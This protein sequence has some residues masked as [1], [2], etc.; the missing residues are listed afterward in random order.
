VEATA[1]SVDIKSKDSDERTL[2]S[3]VDLTM[4]T[5]EGLNKKSIRVLETQLATNRNVKL[6]NLQDCKVT[7][8][9]L[10]KRQ[11]PVQ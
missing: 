10:D 4:V 2:G 1:T 5:V 8:Q 6:N 7:C 11:K 9:L 3:L